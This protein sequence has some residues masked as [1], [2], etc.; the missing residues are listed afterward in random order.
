MMVKTL[1]VMSI[2][3][4]LCAGLLFW[5]GGVQLLGGV[6]QDRPALGTVLGEQGRVL[7]TPGKNGGQATNPLLE[8]AAAFARYLNPPKP[9]LRPEAP[10]PLASA[11]PVPRPSNPAPLFRLLAISYYRASPELSLALIWDP[12]KGG[13]WIREGEQVG[14]FVVEKIEREAICYRDGAQLRQMAVT[15]PVPLTQLDS[16]SRRDLGSSVGTAMVSK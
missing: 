16:G 6:P 12:S 4:L 2:L 7:Q 15:A 1:Y 11:M 13:Y 14:H 3:C 8:Q 9:P 5:R 10:A